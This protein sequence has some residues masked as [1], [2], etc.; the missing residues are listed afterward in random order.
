MGFHRSNRINSDEV[1]FIDSCILEEIELR[2]EIG[3][4]EQIKKSN[5]FQSFINSIKI[6]FGNVYLTIPNVFEQTGIVG[7]ILLYST[8]AVLNSY[9][10][11]T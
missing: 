4:V 5:D 7:G 3:E 11:Y 1:S 6:F 9:T 2:K 8:V 10:M